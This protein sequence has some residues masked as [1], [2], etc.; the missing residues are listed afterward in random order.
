MRIR[1]SPEA[2]ADL[3]A[4][5]NYYESQSPG[6]GKHFRESMIADIETL[7]TLAG[8]HARDYGYQRLIGRTFPFIVYYELKGTTVLIVAVMDGR[9]DPASIERRLRN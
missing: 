6:L 9:S 4:G 3:K 1:M 8:I 5:V 2:K 7:K